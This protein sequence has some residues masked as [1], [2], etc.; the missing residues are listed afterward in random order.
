M[1]AL[2]LAWWLES[3]ASHPLREQDLA[4]T[5]SQRWGLQVEVQGLELQPGAANALQVRIAKLVVRDAG[6]GFAAQLEQVTVQALGRSLETLRVESLRAE[7]GRLE[8]ALDSAGEP[9]LP[10]AFSPKGEPAPLPPFEVRKLDLELA[11]AG[12]ALRAP[13]LQLRNVNDRAT[14]AA[15]RVELRGAHAELTWRGRR[16]ELHEIE[17]SVD[18]TLGTPQLRARVLTALAGEPTRGQLQVGDGRVSVAL[19]LPARKL[20]APGSEAELAQLAGR[21]QLSAEV[22]HWQ[23]AGQAQ[24]TLRVAALSALGELPWSGALQVHDD[25]LELEGTL[26]LAGASWQLR[27]SAAEDGS[28][29]RA[30][31]RAPRVMLGEV[32]LD[33]VTVG[34]QDDGSATGPRARLGASRLRWQGIDARTPSAELRPAWRGAT[35]SWSGRLSLPELRL[36]EYLARATGVADLRGRAVASV[37]LTHV[38]SRDPKDWVAALTLSTLVLTQGSVELSAAEP[39]VAELSAGRLRVRPTRLTA[40]DSELTLAGE[41]ALTAGAALTLT[42]Q[43]RLARLAQVYESVQAVE[44]VVEHDLRLS[45]PWT[46][47]RLTGALLIREARLQCFGEAFEA[48]SASLR[49]EGGALHVERAVASVRDG[50][51]E[52]GG[53]IALDGLRVGA[54]ALQVRAGDFAIEPVPEARAKLRLD[55]RLEAGGPGGVPHVA[56]TLSVLRGAYRHALP[57]QALPGLLAQGLGAETASVAGPARFALDL[58]LAFEP[59]IRIRNNLADATLSVD[60]DQGLRLMGTDAEPRLRGRLQLDGRLLFQS[61]EFQLDRAGFEFRPDTGLWPRTE[62]SAATARGVRLQLSG[63]PSDLS[64]SVRC[65]SAPDAQ[66]PFQCRLRG[67]DARCDRFEELVA[68]FQCTPGGTRVD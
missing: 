10:P 47:P 15:P 39:L 17:L 53:R 33:D 66:R 16:A 36:D 6:R 60:R 41:G 22:G 48:A 29:P 42:G 55:A 43:T 68:R 1:L 44:G 26:Q 12:F 7:R 8:L 62:L 34:Y 4:R 65:D 38:A 54:V 61:N 3:G 24:G 23:W 28:G 46:E 58:A 21:A 56:G 19:D 13:E 32:A 18:A 52:L 50:R 11:A 63:P 37:E 30:E 57:L 67:A 20:R 64:L 40:P 31:L 59:P 35:P 49:L 2:A 27:A 9:R 51:I 5:L 45:G 14:G 25:R